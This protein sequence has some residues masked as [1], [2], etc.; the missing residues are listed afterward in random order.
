M[1]FYTP[2]VSDKKKY[3]FFVVLPNGSR[4]YF[5]ASGYEDYTT[6]KDP[7]RKKKYIQRHQTRENWNDP[8]SAGFW[9]RWY[10]WNLETKEASLKDIRT[11]FKI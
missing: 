4:L 6:H 10:L 7:E 5:G 11:R 8:N 2:Y 3:K 9:S 1:R